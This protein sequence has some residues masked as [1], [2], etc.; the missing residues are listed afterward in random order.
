[1]NFAH[2]SLCSTFF[3]HIMLCCLNAERTMKSFHLP[4][5]P[6]YRLLQELVH[7][8]KIFKSDHPIIVL[9]LNYFQEVFF[10]YVL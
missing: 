4:M 5:F 7:S 9:C 2:T 6:F 8:N 3:C 1:M 10:L